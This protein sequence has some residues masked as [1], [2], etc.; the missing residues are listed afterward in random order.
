MPAFC[1]GVEQLFNVEVGL[2]G[3]HAAL[4]NVDQG[5]A[6]AVLRQTQHRPGMAL[7]EAVVQHE[8][9]LVGVQLQKP[10]LVGKGGLRHAQTLGG[11]GLGAVPQ[12]H[13]IL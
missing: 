12:H 6:A 1:R 13:H 9:P 11:F 8:L 2:S 5:F 4:G 10:Q 3:V 7:G